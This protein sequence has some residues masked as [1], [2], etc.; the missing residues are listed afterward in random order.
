MEALV[1]VSVSNDKRQY[2]DIR[3][4]PD[5]I[6]KKDEEVIY[7]WLGLRAFKIEQ[8]GYHDPNLLLKRDWRAHVRLAHTCVSEVK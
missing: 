8:H 3:D 1:M 7:R 4:S 6:L 5:Y 2:V